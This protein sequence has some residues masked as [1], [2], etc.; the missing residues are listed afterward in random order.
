MQTGNGLR[1]AMASAFRKDAQTSSKVAP[2]HVVTLSSRNRVDNKSASRAAAPSAPKNDASV[3]Q[4]NRVTPVKVVDPFASLRQSAPKRLM[5]GT[6]SKSGGASKN[7]KK[8]VVADALKDKKPKD[9]NKKV[10]R[11]PKNTKK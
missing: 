8:R 5:Q 4:T 11:V 9:K 3:K 1:S 6:A 7:K 10:K 2:I